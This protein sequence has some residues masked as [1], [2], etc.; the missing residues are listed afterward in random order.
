MQYRCC[1]L[2]S[3]GAV[4]HTCSTGAVGLYMQYRC[5][6]QYRCC[7]LYMQ[8]RCC[9]LYMQY[10]CCGSVHAVQVL[11]SVQYRCCGVCVQ[12]RCCG[13]YCTGAIVCVRFTHLIVIIEMLKRTCQTHV[14]IVTTAAGFQYCKVTMLGACTSYILTLNLEWNKNGTGTI[15]VMHMHS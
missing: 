4:V 8:Y 10:R 7:G 15:S 1:G 2:Y 14:A 13:L 11:W 12:Y 6:G 3:T 9:G 5:R